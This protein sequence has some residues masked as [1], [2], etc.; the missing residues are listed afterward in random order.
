MYS[1]MTKNVCRNVMKYLWECLL[2][3]TF[4]FATSINCSVGYE[5]ATFRNNCQQSNRQN[6]CVRRHTM[7]IIRLCCLT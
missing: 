3:F 7:H 6:C 1:E 4:V 2:L 5:T